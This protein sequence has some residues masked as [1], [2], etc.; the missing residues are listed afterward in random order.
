MLIS[1]LS[2]SPNFRAERPA[3]RF[4]AANS[5]ATP[6]LR[7]SAA[8]NSNAVRQADGSFGGQSTRLEVGEAVSAAVRCAEQVDGGFEFGDFSVNGQQVTVQFT[9]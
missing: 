3:N 5:S 6:F 8:K 7:I 9:K 4:P 2:S 1:M